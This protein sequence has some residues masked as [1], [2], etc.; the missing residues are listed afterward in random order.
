MINEKKNNSTAKNSSISG[1]TS[2]ISTENS[3]NSISSSNISNNSYYNNRN[4]NTYNKNRDGNNKFSNYKEKDMTYNMEVLTVDRV[5]CT[6]AGGRSMSFRAIVAIG[7]GKGYI[8]IG[9][10]KSKEVPDAINKAERQAKKKLVRVPMYKKT[11]VHDCEEKF[12]ATK[13]LLKRA[14][15]GSGFITC[16]VIKSIL[17]LSG[18]ENLVAKV[19]GSTNTNNIIMALMKAIK[20]LETFKK[21]AMRRGKN[22]E[23][24]LPI[25]K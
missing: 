9:S 8:G 2:T 23:D 21:I 13:I 6:T 7:D 12:G 1:S 24:I 17:S 14:K 15:S 5:S 11:I 4:N 10:G 18:M 16:N 19:Y 20:N 3:V 22:I 25:R